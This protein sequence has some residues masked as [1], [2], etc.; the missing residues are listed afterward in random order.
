MFYITA[1]HNLVAADRPTLD[2]FIAAREYSMMVVIKRNSAPS[3]TLALN[4]ATLS[5]YTATVL[6]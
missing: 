1:P 2:N 6:P 4:A 5:L 3:S